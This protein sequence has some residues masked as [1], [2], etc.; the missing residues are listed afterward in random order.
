MFTEPLFETDILSTMLRNLTY[1]LGYKYWIVYYTGILFFLWTVAKILMRGNGQKSYTNLFPDQRYDFDPKCQS[2]RLGLLFLSG[3][4]LFSIFIIYS[5]EQT[6]FNNYD[7]MAPNTTYAFK[8][9]ILPMFNIGGRFSPVSFWDINFLYAITHNYY[10][11]NVYVL[12]QVAAI[13]YLFYRFLDFMPVGRRLFLIGLILLMPQLFW[14]YNIVFPERWLL[15]YILLSLNYLKQFSRDAKAGNLWMFILFMN[16]ALYTKENIVLFYFG[17]FVCLVIAEIWQE[18]LTIKHFLHPFSSMREFPIET[19]MFFS[20]FFLS[21]FYLFNASF[22]VEYNPY[23]GERTWPLGKLLLLYK[24]EILVSVAAAILFL[25]QMIKKTPLSLFLGYAAIAAAG[26]AL[27][28][29]IYMRFGPF[30]VNNRSH[31]L[32]V[33]VIFGMIYLAGAVSSKRIL[34]GLFI[35]AFVYAVVDDIRIFKDEP[36]ESYASASK[37]LISQY[38]KDK[39]VNIYIAPHVEPNLW[40]INVWNSTYKYYL[41]KSGVQIHFY[42][43]PQNIGTF[44]FDLNLEH[45]ERNQ[46]DF[47]PLTIKEQP[48]KGEFYV[49]KKTS[50]GFQKDMQ[51]IENLPRELVY[52]NKIFKIY[53]MK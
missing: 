48:E 50:E 5:L 41:R 24:V 19:L 27:F 20:M 49:V 30:P 35:C 14:T 44:A 16:L 1:Y 12:L 38:R 34:Y 17:I 10:L 23:I 4:M 9:G 18:K 15:I 13:A 37:Y 3:V 52:E 2:H 42:S 29:T 28:Q 45:V 11:I 22:F 31:Y 47:F 53:K 46:D 8:N 36:G 26:M 6:L 43:Y 40:T 7:L 39:P 51:V 21:L 32:V 33:A 25:Y